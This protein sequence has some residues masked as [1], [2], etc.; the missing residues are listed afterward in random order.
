MKVT[1]TVFLCKV[2]IMVI[3]LDFYNKY[4]EKCL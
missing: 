2:F 1:L 3:Y 4:K